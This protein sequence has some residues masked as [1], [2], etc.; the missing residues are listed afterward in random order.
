MSTLH[1]ISQ[2]TLHTRF[3]RGA[4]IVLVVVAMAVAAVAVVLA[5]P[6]G[7]G[8]ES[9]TVQ[10]VV[11]TGP[12]SQTDPKYF[13]THPQLDGTVKASDLLGPKSQTDPKYWVTHN[14]P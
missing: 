1:N 13:V 9:P 8:N 11:Q 4:T 6:R 10:G 12:V 2:P 7:G 3:S 5:V 14:L